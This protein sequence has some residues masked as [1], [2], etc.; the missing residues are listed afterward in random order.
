[1]EAFRLTPSQVKKFNK[2][3]GNTL[4]EGNMAI[5]YLNGEATCILQGS[6]VVRT[7]PKI[8]FKL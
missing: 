5:L 2:L 8:A 4:D 6:V 7:T 1:M 3:T